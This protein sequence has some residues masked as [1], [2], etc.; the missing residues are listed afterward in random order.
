MS[1]EWQRFARW[2]VDFNLLGYCRVPKLDDDLLILLDTNN[3]DQV[4]MCYN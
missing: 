4:L 3:E 1:Y 2:L